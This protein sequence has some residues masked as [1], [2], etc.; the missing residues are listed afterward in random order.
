MSLYFF[1][2]FALPL[3]TFPHLC[4]SVAAV[5]VFC[6]EF[7]ALYFTLR[8]NVVTVLNVLRIFA[9]NQAKPK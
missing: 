5:I 9:S 3:H 2:S 6:F 1:F 7:A 8:L 4:G